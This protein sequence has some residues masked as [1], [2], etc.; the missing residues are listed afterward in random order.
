[1]QEQV[2]GFLGI[3][4]SNFVAMITVNKD[5]F[6]FG[7]TISVKFFCD[8]SRVNKPVKKLNVK[9]K[10]K[11]YDYWCSGDLISQSSTD[12]CPAHSVVEKEL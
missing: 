10:R 12:G 11:V 5:G 3:G 4:T 8:N 9:L 6:Y 7:E 1:M 2:G